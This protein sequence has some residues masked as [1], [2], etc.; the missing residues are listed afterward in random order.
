MKTS[1]GIRTHSTYTYAN[2]NVFAQNIILGREDVG[3]LSAVRE[4]SA[5]AYVESDNDNQIRIYLQQFLHPLDALDYKTSDF[6]SD[7][8]WSV[9]GM[10]IHANPSRVVAFLGVTKFN[11]SI[12]CTGV[13]VLYDITLEV[14]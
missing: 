8:T 9:L 5:H 13:D 10:D 6:K 1:R 3:W 7:L 12:E 14:E 4:S 2:S 11:I